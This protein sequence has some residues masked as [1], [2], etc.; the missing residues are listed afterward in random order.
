MNSLEK[1]RLKLYKTLENSNNLISARV[2]KESQKFD[3]LIFES[4]KKGGFFK[5]INDC[6]ECAN[7]GSQF[8]KICNETSG[9]RPSQFKQIE[10]KGENDYVLVLEKERQL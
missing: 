8:C 3:K 7:K 9:G 5:M 1:C 10:N 6:K 4:M 2:I